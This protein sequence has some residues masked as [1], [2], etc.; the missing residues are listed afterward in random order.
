MQA[1]FAACIVFVQAHFFDG[2]FIAFSY[3]CGIRFLTPLN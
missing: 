1:A 2:A 3:F